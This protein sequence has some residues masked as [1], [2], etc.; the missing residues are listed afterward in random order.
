MPTPI[1]LDNNSR[2]LGF[3]WIQTQSLN[4]KGTGELMNVETLD[5]L[6]RF[7]ALKRYDGFC[8]HDNSGFGDMLGPKGFVGGRSSYRFAIVS[9]MAAPDQRFKSNQWSCNSL[10]AGNK[11][12]LAIK[13]EVA[14]RRAQLEAH[15]TN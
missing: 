9:P 4:G 2:G 10:A 15:S 3:Q 7:R 8:I 13:Q 14:E 11:G 1:D 5:H 6:F 12:L